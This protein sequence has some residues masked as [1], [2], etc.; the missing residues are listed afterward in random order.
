[1]EISESYFQISNTRLHV[2]D[3]SLT[4]DKKDYPISSSFIPLIK[5]PNSIYK[6][7]ER[8]NIVTNKEEMMMTDQNI[9]LVT[10]LTA[11]EQ[12]Y[13]CLPIT[14]ISENF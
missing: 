3:E 10:D 4:E 2:D 9:Q 14:K 12:A 11:I 5:I 13:K 8:Q 6:Q 1:M 7:I